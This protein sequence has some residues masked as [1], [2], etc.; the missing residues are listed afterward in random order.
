MKVDYIMDMDNK[1]Y[2]RECLKWI[3]PS[4][5]SRRVPK[6]I[7]SKFCFRVEK[8]KEQLQLFESMDEIDRETIKS[9]V[10]DFLASI[11]MERIPNPEVQ[12]SKREYRRISYS[13]IKEKNAGQKDKDDIVWI[14]FIKGK[15]LISVIGTGCDIFFTDTTKNETVAGIINQQLK[16]EW[17]EDEAFIF[18]LINIPE[19]LDRSDIES[20][21]GNYLISKK[22]PIL[23]FYSHNY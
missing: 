2:L 19:G 15:S 16:L 18:P 6:P 17:D 11:G 12:P 10:N 13:N 9:Y 20:G 21:I 4:I 3:M 8:A 1:E 22:I 7:E 14:K 23:D 5:K